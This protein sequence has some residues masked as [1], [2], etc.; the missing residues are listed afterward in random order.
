[1]NLIIGPNGTGKSTICNAVCIVFGGHPRLLGRSTELG[2]FVKHGES[3]A[4]VEAHLYDPSCPGGVRKV[5]REFD[6]DAKGE[7]RIDDR[8]ARTADMNELKGR[9]DIQLDNLSQF[10][11]Q[12]KIAEFTQLKPDELLAIT[13]RSLGGTEKEKLLHELSRLDQD[14]GSFTA[15]IQQREAE[16]A[17]LRRQQEAE[18]SEVEAYKQQQEVKKLLRIYEK[19]VPE[20]EARELYVQYRSLLERRAHREQ[21][22]QELHDTQNK[23]DT[24]PINA[25]QQEFDAASS[26]FVAARK[27]SKAA[28]DSLNDQVSEADA[29]SLTLSKKITELEDIEKNAARRR[30]AVEQGQQRLVEAERELQ[31]LDERETKQD[32]DSRLRDLDKKR[33][34]VRSDIDSARGRREPLEQQMSDASRYIVHYNNK[35][36]SLADVRQQRIQKISDRAKSRNL[37]ACDR[38]VRQLKGEGAF[39]GDVRG[40]LAAEIEVDNPYHARI[41]ESCVQGFLMA[42]FVTEY[43]SDSRL[44]ISRCKQNFGGW[45]PDVIT[46]PTTAEDERDSYAIEGQVPRRQVDAR[47]RQLGITCVV[48][49]IYKTPPPVRAALNAQTNIHAIHVG[50]EQADRRKEELRAEDGMEAWF[51]PKSRCK[52]VRSRYDRSVRN[53]KV[54]TQFATRQGDLFAGNS[55]AALRERERLI[56][57]IRESEGRRTHAGQELAQIDDR[58]KHFH[59]LMREIDSEVRQ[60]VD[61]RNQRKAKQDRVDQ[62][63]RHLEELQRRTASLDVERQKEMLEKEI[64]RMVEEEA[65]AVVTATKGLVSLRSSMAQLDLQLATRMDSFRRLE[66]EKSKQSEIQKEIEEKQNEVRTAKKDAKEAK[67]E[68]KAKQREAQEALTD[69]ERVEHQELLTSLQDKTVESLEEEMAKE[70][71]KVAGLAT[72]GPETIRAYEFRQRKI[73]RK[74]K[75]LETE[76]SR[77]DQRIGRLRRQK[78]D[79]LT[80]LHAGVEKMR[81]KFSS[82]YRRLGCAG[83]LELANLNSDRIGDL[84][85]QILVSYR[86]DAALRPISASANSGGEKMCCTMLFCFSLLLEEERMPPFVFV[87]ELNQGLDPSNEMKIMTMM[88]EDAEQEVAPQSFVIT[89]K[90]LLNL[91]F[92]AR[93]KTHIIFNGSVSGK[94]DVSA[95]QM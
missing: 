41:M 82:L 29:I 69:S 7:F 70:R 40:P 44:L 6:T 61:H 24:G 74:T 17:D 31:Q 20:V 73:D 25:L 33:R 12:E 72:S 45:A 30:A 34:G 4:T 88:F 21:E 8:R 92:H 54:D 3:K 47:L 39:R 48:N 93:T 75:E 87:D 86:D 71:G 49:D 84:E 46:A 18:A 38:F 16:L 63:K 60:V 58:L 9:Y 85:L 64:E 52:V 80:W 91:P 62:M 83:D 19:C 79:F 22:L 77:Y 66:A 37:E 55:E 78:E 68:W 95:P 51:T 67:N 50:D 5:T 23:A 26:S 10:M 27:R 11:P 59:G 28:G 81:V 94:L 1:M 42:A 89:P 90:L 56:G 65:E 14:V 76:R 32:L 13:V 53:L 43:S 15:N 57:V 2:A 35:L 36:S